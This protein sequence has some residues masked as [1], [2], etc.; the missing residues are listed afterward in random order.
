MTEI[1]M[2]TWDL[3]NHSDSWKKKKK[4]SGAIQASNKKATEAYPSLL[5]SVVLSNSLEGIFLIFL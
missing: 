3:G 1:K 4:N 5:P 2:E